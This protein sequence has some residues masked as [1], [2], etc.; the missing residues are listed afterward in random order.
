MDAKKAAKIQKLEEKVQ[1]LQQE[2]ERENDPQKK[3]KLV[4]QCDK[5]Q[6]KLVTIK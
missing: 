1:K 5:L 3:K 2:I 6:I 4:A